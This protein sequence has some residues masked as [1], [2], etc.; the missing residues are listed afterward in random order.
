VWQRTWRTLAAA[1]AGGFVWLFVAFDQWDQDRPLFWLD[2]ALG[3]LGLVLMQY[4]RR[5][6][7]VIAIALALSGAASISTFGA[8]GIV[9]ISLA[10]RRR[11]SETVPIGLLS[12]GAGQ[13]FVL[14]QPGQ[15]GEWLINIVMSLLLVGVTIAMGMYIGARRD[16][17]ESLRDRAERAE[18]E[19]SLQVASAQ[20]Q[21]RTRIAR[22]MHD[23]LA[24]RMSLVAVHAGAL[25]YRS[26]LTAAEIRSTAEIIQAN[27]HR[28]LTDLREI[29]GVLRDAEHGVD[30]TAHRPQ[31][32]LVSLEE[33][34]DDERAAGARVKLRCQLDDPT[35][36]PESVGRTAYRIVQEG[37]TNARK[38]AAGATVRVTITGRPG[39]GLDV[40]VRNP[41]RVGHRTA[42]VGG[43]GYGL[44]GLAERATASHGRFEHGLT[45]DGDFVVRSWLPWP[46]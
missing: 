16:L 39:T 3:V 26:D 44:I 22:E 29:L 25:A 5:W 15:E 4:R 18:R 17:F 34:I 30:I 32:S 24:H 8:W 43:A 40:E 13:V 14:T 20:A 38:H 31:P 21:E 35:T 27:S 7:V 23:V 37:L 9:C 28:A 2:L 6:P 10:T 41:M 42:D 33:L 36:V 46:A 12:I 1:S 11:W 19:Q 45:P